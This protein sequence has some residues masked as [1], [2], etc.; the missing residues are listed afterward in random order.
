[1]GSHSSDPRP[2]SSAGRRTSKSESHSNPPRPESNL[3]SQE[4]VSRR[5]SQPAPGSRRTRSTGTGSIR[6]DGSWTAP[7][8]LA[9]KR[10]QRAARVA[11]APDVPERQANRCDTVY[12][13]HEDFTPQDQKLP[14]RRK[15]SDCSVC[16]TGTEAHQTHSKRRDAPSDKSQQK[17]SPKA[18]GHRPRQEVP[19]NVRHQHSASS[20][21]NATRSV[22]VHQQQDLTPRRDKL[23]SLSKDFH[24]Q[25]VNPMSN[26]YAHSS[27]E[28]MS[29]SF[30]SKKVA[31]RL[32]PTRD[33]T[34]RPRSASLTQALRFTALLAQAPLADAGLDEKIVPS[35]Y[36]PQNRTSQGSRF[37]GC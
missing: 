13:V 5:N 32:K 30:A 21:P 34:E 28:G 36:N 3:S 24:N 22:H 15:G 16:V 1:M 12:T 7:E 2:S 14:A 17:I 19:R 37:V 26:H 6:S 18:V 9:W 11:R 4:H 23:T 29:S 31:H 20:V 35:R 25:L 27:E 10:P 8:V 33:R